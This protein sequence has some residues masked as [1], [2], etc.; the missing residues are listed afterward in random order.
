[1]N[2]NALVWVFSGLLFLGMLF[3]IWYNWEGHLTSGLLSRAFFWFGI[4]CGLFGVITQLGDNVNVGNQ[5]FFGDSQ[6]YFLLGSLSML[7]AIYWNTDKSN[8][9]L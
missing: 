2:I 9:I 7:A 4:V 5:T 1:M 3:V 8:R 6:F